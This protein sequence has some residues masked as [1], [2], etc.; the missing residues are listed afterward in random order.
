M[1]K[2]DQRQLDDF[3]RRYGIA[4]NDVQKKEFK[5][6]GA[7]SSESE[8]LASK[9]YSYWK[10]VGMLLLKSPVFMISLVFII[11]IIIAMFA[12]A[13]PGTE[14]IPLQ[15]GIGSGPAAPTWAHPFGLG[16][17]GEDF[18]LSIWSGTR[19]TLLFALLIT[20]IQVVVGVFLGSIWG[21]FKKTD[22]WFIQLTNFLNL[23]PFMI[24]I[25]FVLFIFN[26]RN[27]WVLVFAISLQIWI[28]MAATVRIQVILVK[29]TDYNTASIFLGSRPGRIIMRNI[30]PRILP[31]IA[32]TASLGIP[33]AIG[34]DATLTFLGFGYI[35]PSN[36]KQTSLGLI[37]TRVLNGTEYQDYPHLIIFPVLMITL[38]SLLFYLLG[39]V[40]ADSLD[41]KSHR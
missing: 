22:I 37:L 4:F 15:S 17:Q 5:R 18:A 35:D 19:T 36:T 10:S 6:V 33:S 28:T 38:I 14:L 32:Q 26:S 23:I 34:L 7:H 13:P 27:Y 31:V 8:Q 41:P 9:P 2:L 24:L 29:N 1:P 16:L 3:Q 39:K 20:L 40:F 12:I 25:L 11:G 21:Y 30:L